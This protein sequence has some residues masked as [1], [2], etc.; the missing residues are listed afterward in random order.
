MDLAMRSGG[1]RMYQRTGVSDNLGGPGFFDHFD[2]Q[3]HNATHND[4][5]VGPG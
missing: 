2:Y 1:R 5:H 4:N 3:T